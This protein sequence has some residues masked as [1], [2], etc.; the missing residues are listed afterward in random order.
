MSLVDDYN[1][2]HVEQSSDF[3]SNT[4]GKYID[5]MLKTHG[6]EKPS[7]HE[8]TS[9]YKPILFST[10]VVPSL[11][12]EQGL[13]EDTQEHA[14]L[15]DKQGFYYQSFFGKLMFTY[16]ACL[17]DIGYYVTTLSKFFMAPAAI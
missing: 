7:P 10:K 17:P 16:A 12:K 13:L 1:G 11:Y 4:G 2:V 3:V 6:W 8:A 9:D 15:A 5:P 14:D